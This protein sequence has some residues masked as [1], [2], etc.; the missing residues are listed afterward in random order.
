MKYILFWLILCLLPACTIYKENKISES[1]MPPYAEIVEPLVDR[2]QTGAIYM[3]NART[4][5]FTSRYRARN[6]G[7]LLTVY[8]EEIY[9]ATKA[10]SASSGK[11]ENL[12]Y[13]LPFKMAGLASRLQSTGTANFAGTGAAAQSNSFTGEISVT[14]IRVFN[15]GNLEVMGQKQILLN[16][17]K[18]YIRLRGIVRPEDIS[19]TNRVSS[20]RIANADIT[21]TG[22]GD[23][24]DSGKVGWLGR[25]IRALSPL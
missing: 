4:S 10:Q 22:A 19:T 1:F 25:L 8:F 6:V 13:D 23:I 5:L 15:N 20:L 21:Y 11:S 18:E 16:N 24:A 7:D 9:N 3:A 17:G 14:V 12:R 2:G